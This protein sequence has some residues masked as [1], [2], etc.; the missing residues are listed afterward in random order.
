MNT[1]A[2]MKQAAQNMEALFKR[3]ALLSNCCSAHEQE[4]YIEISRCPECKE[5][6]EWE[7]E[8]DET[9]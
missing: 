9:T 1:E 5:G 8:A 2:K 3:E 6:C 7:A 4:G